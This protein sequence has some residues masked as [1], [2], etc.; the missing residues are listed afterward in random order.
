[1]CFCYLFIISHGTP[2]QLI[3]IA[4]RGGLRLPLGNETGRTW[5]A[6]DDVREDVTPAGD[7][8]SWQLEGTAS[9]TGLDV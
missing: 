1:M 3:Q 8:T 6:R 2:W 5:N 7:V 4:V 9:S